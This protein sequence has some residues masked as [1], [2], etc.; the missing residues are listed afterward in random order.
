MNQTT[1]TFINYQAAQDSIT[2]LRKAQ[3]RYKP[4]E[5]DPD[6]KSKSL[7][8]EY[9]D[10]EVDFYLTTLTLYIEFFQG[11]F[12]FDS[13]NKTRPTS[14][15]AAVYSPFKEAGVLFKELT[16]FLTSYHN[17][18]IKF[19]VLLNNSSG[20]PPS[21]GVLLKE[22]FL[23][24]IVQLSAFE[25]VYESL[26]AFLDTISFLRNNQ[27][28]ALAALQELEESVASRK[29]LK[30]DFV[31]D[32]LSAVVQHVPKYLALL[33][34][35]KK[36]AS[37]TEGE[38][39]DRLLE[40]TRKTLEQL[41]L[42][43]RKQNADGETYRIVWDKT[44]KN[45][46]GRKILLQTVA[47]KFKCYSGKTENVV[48]KKGEFT[49]VLTEGALLEIDPSKNSW[50]LGRNGRI[51]EFPLGSEFR[52]NL[53]PNSFI[54]NISEV[55]MQKAL[56]VGYKEYFFFVEFRSGEEKYEWIVIISK[57]LG[58]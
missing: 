44:A 1:I 28:G 43:Q 47:T 20:K 36:L 27:P 46:L 5:E 29:D 13:T 18:L 21:P 14:E 33:Q 15:G 17:L 30:K 9:L 31:L 50:V 3:E 4:M 2:N 26:A 40:T 16:H 8:V 52:F 45:Y 22:L 23:R 6:R 49:Y 39:F 35:A 7:V 32:S 19:E 54:K 24:S 25:L 55:D 11:F 58:L 10:F 12:Y 48:K 42:V 51:K 56:Q 53:Y 57:L 34:K 41:D 38:T 37:T